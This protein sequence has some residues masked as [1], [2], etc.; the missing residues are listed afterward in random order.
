METKK[1]AAIRALRAAFPQTI[2][3]MAG[4]VLT[5]FSAAQILSKQNSISHFTD[6]WT[7]RVFSVGVLATWYALL[8]YRMSKSRWMSK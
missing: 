6:K 7:E 3:I 5:V 2:P 1:E 8:Y 4:Y